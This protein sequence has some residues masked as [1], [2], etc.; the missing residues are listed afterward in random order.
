MLDINSFQ[1]IFWPLS[2]FKQ[3]KDEKWKIYNRTSWYELRFRSQ[4]SCQLF[5]FILWSMGLFAAVPQVATEKNQHTACC[6]SGV[7]FLWL[8]ESDQHNGTLKWCTLAKQEVSRLSEKSWASRRA[9][10]VTPGSLLLLLEG[11]RLLRSALP[12]SK[13]L[14]IYQTVW[15]CGGC[16]LSVPRKHLEMSG[17]VLSLLC[18]SQTCS[19][20]GKKWKMVEKSQSAIIIL[21]EKEENKISNWKM[22]CRYVGLIS[23]KK[24]YKS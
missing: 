23:N 6:Q 20:E 5:I 16:S 13:L 12:A 2:F 19:Y 1:V 8:I 11:R 17:R 14:G 15:F 7:Q 24:T 21:R 3:L 18:L 4:S 10:K 22:D 9:L